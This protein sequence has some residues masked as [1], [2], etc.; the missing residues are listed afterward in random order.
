[1]NHTLHDDDTPF[2]EKFEGG[3]HTITIDYI[4]TMYIYYD[5]D[6]LLNIEGINLKY[7]NSC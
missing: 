2:R 7:L 3:I 6:I 4:H 5:T 1:M